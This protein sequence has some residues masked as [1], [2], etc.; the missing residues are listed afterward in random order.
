MPKNPKNGGNDFTVWRRQEVLG[1]GLKWPKKTQ[2]GSLS[3]NLVNYVS[4]EGDNG[5]FGDFWPKTG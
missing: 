2:K 4:P 3:D 1:L 5:A